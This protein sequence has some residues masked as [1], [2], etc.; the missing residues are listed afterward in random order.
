MKTS[1]H[2]QNLRNISVSQH[3]ATCSLTSCFILQNFTDNNCLDIISASKNCRT[4][5]KLSRVISENLQDEGLYILNQGKLKLYKTDKNGQ[6][7]IL[8]FIRPGEIFSFFKSKDEDE[9]QFY[10]RAL[11]DSAICFLN[12]DVLNKIICKYPE[13]GSHFA[14]SIYQSLIELQ[15]RYFKATQMHVPAKVA[16]ALIMMYDAFGEDTFGALNVK[17]SREDIAGLATTTKEQVSKVFSELKADGIIKAK[18]KKI[19]ILN[20][21]LLKKAA[22]F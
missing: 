8:R 4:Y 14:Q 3:C 7:I 6:E 18:G 9:N 16:D 5:D 1:Q 22:T 19:E 12:K 15:N 10:L 21:T 2:N 20:L 17:L 11:E 13:V